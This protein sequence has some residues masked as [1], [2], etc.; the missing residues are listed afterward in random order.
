MKNVYLVII[1]IGLA[2]LGGIGKVGA[3]TFIVDHP[4]LFIGGYFITY[5]MYKYI[6][7]RLKYTSARRSILGL[8]ILTIF[9]LLMGGN[10]TYWNIVDSGDVYFGLLPQWFVGPINGNDFMWNGFGMDLIIGRVVPEALIP[11]YR[12]VGFNIL[13]V[14]SWLMCP[15]TLG[16]G[17]LRGNA[18]ALIKNPSR[19][20]LLLEHAKTI[21]IGLFLGLIMIA[22]ARALVSVYL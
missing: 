13:A 21:G 6:L 11:T 17:C 5:W 10:L 12:Y 18:L 2:I 15:V 14:I 3:G 22:L 19:S 20:R 4:C 9:F 8:F 1:F 7:P 16:W